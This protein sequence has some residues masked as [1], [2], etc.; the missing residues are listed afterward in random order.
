MSNKK[1]NNKK[2][3]IN[4]YDVFLVLTSLLIIIGGIFGALY[5]FNKHDGGPYGFGNIGNG[6]MGFIIIF[7]T[8]LILLIVVLYFTGAEVKKFDKNMSKSNKNNWQSYYF[9]AILYEYSTLDLPLV[10]L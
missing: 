10:S 7:I 3:K 6:I 5:I 2:G 1:D 4:L 9:S 8:I